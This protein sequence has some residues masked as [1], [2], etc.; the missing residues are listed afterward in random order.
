[1]ER[2]TNTTLDGPSLVY[3][4]V[5][6]VYYFLTFLF[7]VGLQERACVAIRAIITFFLVLPKY[8]RLS[9]DEG[10]CFYGLIKLNWVSPLSLPGKI[11]LLDTEERGGDK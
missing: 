4:T 5:F 9:K 10:F 8:C 11:P 3:Q 7:P 6:S 1:M 2:Q